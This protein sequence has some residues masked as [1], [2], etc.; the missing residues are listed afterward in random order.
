MCIFAPN[1]ATLL[2][3]RIIEA[4]AAGSLMP[5]IQNVILIMFPPAKRGMAMGITGLVIGFGPA[6][7]PTI[8][9]LILKYADWQM[10]L[11]F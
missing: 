11:L 6:V 2:V 7:G 8:S 4:V 9:G 1:F 3:G 5:F 10:L